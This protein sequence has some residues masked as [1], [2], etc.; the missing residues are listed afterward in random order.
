MPGSGRTIK[1]IV[2]RSGTTPPR[3]GRLVVSC[4]KS[5]CPRTDGHDHPGYHCECSYHQESQHGSCCSHHGD[6]GHRRTTSS[7]G[8]GPNEDRH[9]PRHSDGPE[10]DF[11]ARI[12]ADTGLSARRERDRDRRLRRAQ[13][14]S[15]R[16]EVIASRCRRD[17]RTRATIHT[18]SEWFAHTFT[19][20]GQ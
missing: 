16:V 11:V 5:C 7:P 1:T 10:R 20:R 18:S 3:D 6:H 14:G 15:R 13:G 12:L 2:A 17:L 19:R 8:R 9:G 4:H